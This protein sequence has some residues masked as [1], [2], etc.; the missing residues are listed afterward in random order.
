S[1]ACGRAA[2]P[3]DVFDCCCEAVV[4]GARRRLSKR[5]TIAGC[6]IATHSSASV[7]L[8]A[9]EGLSAGDQRRPHLTPCSRTPGK[10]AS[11]PQYHARCA[12]PIPSCGLADH[13]NS[14]VT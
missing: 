13:S 10:P 2:T 9:T 7:I 14:E 12:Q 1:S 5:L 8:A 6:I 4:T 3:A 11:H